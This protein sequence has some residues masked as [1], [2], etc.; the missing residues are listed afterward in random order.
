MINMHNLYKNNN[1]IYQRSHKHITKIMEEL[2]ELL[3]KM[4]DNFS[5][6]N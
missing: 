6:E 2:N 4:D 3:E 5:K 1:I